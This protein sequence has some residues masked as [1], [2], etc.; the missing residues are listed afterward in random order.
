MVPDQTAQVARAIFPK[1]NAVMRLY[2]D[3]PVVVAD[4][5]CADLFPARG[6][7]AEAP[8]RLALATLL[9]FL[10]GRTDRQA[11]DAV[12]T[13]YVGHAKTHLAH[14]MTAA[15]LNLVRRLRWLAGGPKAQT[16]QSA[17]ARGPAGRRRRPAPRYAVASAGA[18][19]ASAGGTEAARVP[20][21][22][23]YG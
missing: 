6:Q 12:R 5:D 9:Q 14:L 17:F 8:V 13:P 16:R 1:G 15:A 23:Q 3:L 4:R 7:P 21:D 18:P 2:D 11:A 20:H 19:A 10:E 22:G